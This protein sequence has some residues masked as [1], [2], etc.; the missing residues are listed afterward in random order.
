M[1]KLAASKDQEVALTI[2][3][4]TL[5][6]IL[7]LIVL[8][9][10]VLAALQKATHALIL[11]FVAFF[12]AVALNAPVSWVSRHLPGPMRNNRPLALA[13]SFL[14]V[15]AIIGVFVVSLIP[16]IARQT[17][18]FVH[19]APTL[20]QDVYSSNSQASQIIAKYHLQSQ[21]DAIS[22]ELS[23]KLQHSSDSAISAVIG[24]GSSVFSSLTILVLTFMMLIEGPRWL[25]VM[26]ALIPEDRQEY[27]VRISRDM[28]K[29]VRG[30]VYGQVVLAGLAALLLLP[31]M[32]IFHV[33]YPIALMGVVFVCALIPM[34]GHFIGAA[35]V[36]T[37]AVFHSPLSAV[38]IL[39][40][41]IL[42]QQ[43]ETYLIQPKIQSNSTDLSPLLVLMSL[44]VGVS[45]GGLVGGL[46]AI[47]IVACIRVWV[48][49]YLRS[50]HLITPPGSSA[51]SQSV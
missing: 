48:V 17:G 9:I 50:R 15:I 29:A 13:L 33:S 14:I 42:Y 40:Y 16:P 49:D 25:K 47:P 38:G 3:N 2:T 23:T 39:V 26:Y 46:V 44:V 19:N 10:L 51:S 21:I 30:Y 7:L 45:F 41:Y 22:G 36:T 28:Y 6:R 8:V 35:I 12:L 4:R 5:L 27:V 24:V 11:I 37:V 43:I 1:A 18:A 32:L 34:V 31:G 20:L